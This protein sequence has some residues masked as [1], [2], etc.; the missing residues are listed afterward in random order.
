VSVLNLAW[1]VVK[2]L[3]VGMMMFGVLFFLSAVVRETAAVWWRQ[4][5]DAWVIR[6]LERGRAHYVRSPHLMPRRRRWAP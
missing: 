1:V 2:V 6:Q 5:R 3:L 4:L